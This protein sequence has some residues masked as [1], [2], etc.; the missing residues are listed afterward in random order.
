[1]HMRCNSDLP[2]LILLASSNELFWRA[3]LCAAPQLTEPLEYATYA[4]SLF[5]DCILLKNV[6]TTQVSLEIV[7]L[8]S[9]YET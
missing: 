6:F 5:V 2:R 1:M 3:L 4:S 9:S 7:V 8:F